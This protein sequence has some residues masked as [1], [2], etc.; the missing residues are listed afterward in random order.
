MNKFFRKVILISGAV[1]G[2]FL[3]SCQDE[4]AVTAIQPS[5]N[6]TGIAQA[7]PLMTPN[8]KLFKSG[9]ETLI[10]N[11]DGR[12]KQVN[13]TVDPQYNGYNTYRIDYEYAGNSIVVTRY[14]EN[15]KESKMEWELQN[16]RAA[17]SKL[18]KYNLGNS[19]VLSTFHAAYQYNA[20]DQ[21]VKVILM[22]KILKKVTIDYDSNGDAVKFQMVEDT[23]NGDQFV[24]MMK[25]EYTE[26]VG[27]PLEIDKGETLALHVCS[28]STLGSIAD[29]YL[30][31]FG[32]F[33]K[34]L[35]K[36]SI[37]TNYPATFR[38]TYKLDANGYVNEQTTLKN[39]GAFVESKELKY[40]VPI[41]DRI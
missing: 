34:H 40:A 36:K 38:Y 24:N 21:L 1:C 3:I 27:G 23:K 20:Q 14:R 9:N 10:Y 15:V 26:Y 25:Y 18:T 30:P 29:P 2:L 5:E 11:A 37:K 41:K 4:S 31:I 39:N 17:K 6:H 13:G 19:N 12:I 8:F 7:P 28:P 33:G 32:K 22:D 35:L 16:G